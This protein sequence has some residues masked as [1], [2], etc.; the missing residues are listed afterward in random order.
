VGGLERSAG[1]FPVPGD[2]RGPFVEPVRVMLDEGCGHGGVE[3]GPPPGEEG[4]V[5]DFLGEGMPE[6]VIHHAVPLG[7][8]EKLGGAQGPQPVLQVVVAPGRH[9]SE[10]R[11][12]EGASNDRCGLEQFLVFG[13]EPVDAGGEHGLH[14]GRH[15]DL[16]EGTDEAPR[17]GPTGERPVLDE[18]PNDL[19]DEERV[20][21]G[22]LGHEAQQRRE[23]EVDAEEPAQQLPDG[24]VAEGGEGELAIVGVAHPGGG[25]VGTE[26]RYHH[27]P[28]A[29]V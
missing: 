14:A 18:G 6:A 11:L 8:L 24:V 27:G 25:E 4:A 5:G 23:G 13:G 1:P 9:R 17:A 26:V 10:D 16:V 29:G 2:H 21:T 19:F 12:R 3:T 15:L 28:G 22:P 20:A 7:L